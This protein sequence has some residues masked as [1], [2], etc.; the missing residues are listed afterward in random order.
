M[1]SGADP[2]EVA[3]WLHRCR[4]VDLSHSLEA[5]IPAVQRH[6][7]FGHILYGSHDLGH[8]ACHYQLVMS[9][10]SGTHIDAPLH[11]ITEGPARYGTER[12]SLKR[13]LGRA[14]TIQATDIPAGETL[15]AER[16]RGWEEESGY[17][18]AGDAVFLRYGWDLLW[19]TGAEAKEFLAG[20]P[21]LGS[22]AAEY[23]VERGV[24]VVGSDTISI[25]ASSD[26][27]QP[28]HYI[29]LGSEV[30]IMENLNNLSQLPPFCVFMALPLK[31]KGGSGSPVRAIAL[32]EDPDESARGAEDIQSQ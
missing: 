7:R 8:A 25:D 32:V 29:L 19:S 23:L 13:V 4:L 18:E 26:Q 3:R 11:F 20:W 5:G 12:M 21:G 30:Y 24:S 31:V 16:V 17:L 6:A 22:D 15:S 27:D 1:F 2:L 10:H 9:E 28:A 14:A